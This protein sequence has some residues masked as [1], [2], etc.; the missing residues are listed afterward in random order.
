MIEKFESLIEN[1]ENKKVHKLALYCIGKAFGDIFMELEQFCYS[2][3]I[4]KALKNL[5]RKW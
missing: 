5:C 4:Y 3:K 2:I 1:N